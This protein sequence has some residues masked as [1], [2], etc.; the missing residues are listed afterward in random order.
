MSYRCV[1]ARFGAVAAMAAFAA[2]TVLAATFPDKPVKLVVPFAPGGGTDAIA[3]ALGAVG[4]A[5]RRWQRR[6]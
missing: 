2:S 1:L 4:L 5:D 6:G 3:R